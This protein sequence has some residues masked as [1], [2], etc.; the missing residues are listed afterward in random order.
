[1]VSR[2]NAGGFLENREIDYAGNPCWQSDRPLVTR[3]I[4]Q[5]KLTTAIAAAPVSIG[6]Y[7]TGAEVKLTPVQPNKNGQNLI[8]RY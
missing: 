7:G 3:A 4:C 1:V 8:R 6:R 2:E 5:S